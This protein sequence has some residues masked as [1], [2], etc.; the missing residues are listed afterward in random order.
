M[1]ATAGRHTHVETGEV[2]L[3]PMPRRF[4]ICYS[5]HPKLRLILLLKETPPLGLQWKLVQLHQ[6]TVQKS[7]IWWGSKL[8]Q[9]FMTWKELQYQL[10]QMLVK[11]SCG[12][13]NNGLRAPTSSLD[14]ISG[15]SLSI[16]SHT[17]ALARQG[18][19]GSDLLLFQVRT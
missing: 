8:L 10:F 2:L 12:P 19:A 7:L 18:K 11:A 9:G 14:L 1:Q 6:A 3:L 5:D 15:P 17:Q 13:R 4:S 16:E